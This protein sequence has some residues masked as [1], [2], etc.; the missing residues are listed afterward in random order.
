LAPKKKKCGEEGGGFGMNGY[1]ERSS[2]A[3]LNKKWRRRNGGK[4]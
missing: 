4:E 2:R 1:V 3:I